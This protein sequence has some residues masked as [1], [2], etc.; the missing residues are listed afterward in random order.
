MRRLRV[1]YLGHSAALSGAELGLVELIRALTDVEAHVLLAEDGPL[2]DRLRA[3]GAAVE[4]VPLG[5]RPRRLRRAAVRP[6]LA[7]A[8]AAVASAGYSVRLAQRLRAL[9]PDLVHANTLKALLY[10]G[11]AARLAG[12]P[13]VWHVH[14]R[15]A[16]DYLPPL[17]ARLVRA[18]APHVARGVI[19]NSET[20]LAALGLPQLRAAVVHEPVEQPAPDRPAAPREAFTVTMVGRLAPWK[21]Q[22]VFLRAFARAFPAGPERAVIVGS[23]LFGE[24][25]YASSLERLIGQLGLA[26]RVELRG[27]RDDVAA[28]LAQTDAL[29]HASVIA[30]PFGRVVVEGM[31]AGLPVVAANAGGPTEI[32][33]DG[34][35]GLLVQ[36][37]DVDELAAALARLAAEPGLRDRLGAAAR[38]RARAF[39]PAAAAS[40]TARFYRD[41]LEERAA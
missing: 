14:D 16:D 30:E 32:V 7:L 26:G 10:G 17:A 18:V 27:F 36:P 4:L 11:P 41:V 33:T 39:S 28:E 20:T 19:A 24:H 23:A 25:A 3:S 13:L 40:Q 29:V 2:V 1:A 35:D 38:V 34:A 21:G 12:T 22:D 9:H 37:G 5:D 15:V 8:P 6:G 31:A